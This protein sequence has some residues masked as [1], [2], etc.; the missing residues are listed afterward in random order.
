MRR[1]TPLADDQERP[2][3]A[4]LTHF[5]INSDDVERDRAFYERVFGWT[6]SAFGPPGF[7]RIATGD[8]PNAVG[9]AIQ[10]RRELVEG[11][12]TIGYECSMAVDDVDAVVAT[13]VRSGGTMLMERTTITGVGHLVAFADPSGNAVLAMNYDSAAE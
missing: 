12:P 9:G 8:D 7:Y 13:V 6:F 11:T 3:P 1:I 2:M 5:A 10:A 4:P